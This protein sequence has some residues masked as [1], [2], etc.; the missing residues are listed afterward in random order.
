[1]S[2]RKRYEGGGH[3]HGIDWDSGGD[4]TL[5]DSGQ[6]GPHGDFGDMNQ[7]GEVNVL[8]VVA[9]VDCIINSNGQD[10]SSQAASPEQYQTAL[11]MANRQMKQGGRVKKQTRRN[12][13]KRRGGRVRG[14]RFGRGGS[15]RLSKRGGNGGNQ[16]LHRKSTVLKTNRNLIHRLK[17]DN[18]GKMSH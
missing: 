9:L 12:T 15:T 14:K 10:C 1:M 13:M 16:A 5:P 8:D 4:Y 3:I 18:R 6:H 2:K 7:D 17:K 11:K